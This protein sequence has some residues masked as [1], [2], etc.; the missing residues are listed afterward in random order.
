MKTKKSNLIETSKHKNENQIDTVQKITLKRT[1]SK[2][3]F[4]GKLS[5]VKKQSNNSNCHR[6][7]LDPHHCHK[8]QH[9]P[10]HPVSGD[11]DLMN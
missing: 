2:I 9:H 11:L 6:S 8:K 10:T 1:K 3:Y 5:Q 7:G 4:F